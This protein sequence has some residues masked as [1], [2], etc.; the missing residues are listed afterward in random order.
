ME[1]PM[2]NCKNEKINSVVD[3]SLYLKGQK[4][5]PQ[6]ITEIL[7]VEPTHTHLDGELVSPKQEDSARYHGAMW[8]TTVEAS[9]ADVSKVL[10]DLFE[11]LAERRNVDLSAL[12]HV[13]E[14]FIDVYISNSVASSDLSRCIEFKLTPGVLKRAAELGIAVCFSVSNVSEGSSSPDIDGT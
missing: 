9:S 8:S 11:R 3:V 4:L 1:S 10:I 2:D 12:P 7:G 6:E 13:E 14:G 5:V